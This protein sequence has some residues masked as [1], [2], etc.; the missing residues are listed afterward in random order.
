M[1]SVREIHEA[2]NISHLLDKKH[3]LFLNLTYKDNTKW[4][5][6]AVCISVAEEAIRKSAVMITALMEVWGCL[7]IHTSN[8]NSQPI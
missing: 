2:V 1:D 3:L 6:M 7:T 4:G 5:T 8:S